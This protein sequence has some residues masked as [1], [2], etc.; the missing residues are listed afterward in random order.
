MKKLNWAEHQKRWFGKWHLYLGIFAGIIVAFVGVTGSILTFQ[1]EIDEALNPALFQVPVQKQMLSFPQVVDIIHK[2]YPNLSYSY[3]VIPEKK[4]PGSTYELFNTVAEEQVFINPYNGNIVG[5]RNYESSFIAIVTELHVSLFIP[6]IGRYFVGICT[7]ILLILTISGLRLWIPAKWKFLR[8]MLTVKFSGSF[9]RQNYDWHNVLGFYT[10][11]VVIVLSLTGF[12]ISFSVLFIPLLFLLNGESPKGVASLLNAQS[13]IQKNNI[14]I[15]MANVLKIASLQMPEAE[16]R[17]VAMPAN[18]QGSYRLDLMKDG[19]P[20]SGQR[21]ML[22]LDQYSGKVLLNSNKDFP[23]VGLAYLS[24]LTPLHYGSFGG[25]PTKII[26]LI[27]GLIPLILC[28]TGFI[29]WWPRLKKQQ[30]DQRKGKKKIAEKTVLNV[31]V[32]TGPYLLF[33]LKKGLVYGLWMLLFAAI[34]G[35]IYGLVAGAFVQAALFTV[36][37]CT[38]LIT[39]NFF[40]ALILMLLNTVFLMPFKRS[41]RSVS[42]YF[43]WSFSIFIIFIFTYTLINYSG[44]HVF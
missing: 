6:V 10:A 13:T 24:W 5:R 29:I 38:L 21:Q 8:Q 37:F 15:D 40:V 2:K 1:D 33:H 39:V 23:E 41:F 34:C 43:S 26:A 18:K 25:M 44:I 11:P 35:G 4:K 7:L 3:V 30:R 9:K 27:G 32:L 22:S 42:R 16:V 19:F 31:Q 12:L 36:L 17:G 28:I 14:P 20:S